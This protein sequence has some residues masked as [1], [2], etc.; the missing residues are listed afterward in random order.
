MRDGDQAR[1]DG[2]FAPEIE[3]AEAAR[4]DARTIGI[5][6]EHIAVGDGP[7]EGVVG[8]SEHLGSDTFLKVEVDNI[9]TLN[10]RASG[11]VTLRAEGGGDGMNFWV[12]GG[13]RDSF[14]DS[15]DAVRTGI[16][17][18]PAVLAACNAWE[19][20]QH[21]PVRVVDKG[22]YPWSEHY[23]ALQAEVQTPDELEEKIMRRMTQLGFASEDNGI[24]RFLPP[25]HRFLDVCLSVQQDR[26]LAASL[27]SNLPLPTP[28]LLGDELEDDI[29]SLAEDEPDLDEEDALARAM[30]D[31]RYF[32]VL[33]DAQGLPAMLATYTAEDRKLQ[34]QRLNEVKEGRED[35]MQVWTLGADGKPRSLGIIESKYKTLQ[36]PVLPV[37]LQGATEL[38]ISA[39]NKG[40]VPES[41]G[42]RLPY[43]FQGWW[44]QKATAE[45]GRA[46]RSDVG[47]RSRSVS[48]VGTQP[49]RPWSITPVSSCT[50]SGEF[51]GWLTN[52]A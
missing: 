46:N 6:P 31:T 10:V 4:H 41:A 20:A 11:E 39:E 18:N 45:S 15:S 23:S 1:A 21:T 5:R 28:V 2:P 22:S 49:V 16:A 25:M 50:A 33:T 9:G 40:G 48:S 32:A 30:A 47:G 14:G 29:I 19:D 36:L 3:G 37:D 44:I 26:D 52:S 12:E 34:L 43:L 24:Y 35:S 27:H 7:W 13:Y 8:L 38:A 17:A 51:C 42:P